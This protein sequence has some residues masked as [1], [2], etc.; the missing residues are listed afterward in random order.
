MSTMPD[1]VV[2]VVDATNLERNLFLTTQ[3]IDMDIRVVIALN[4]YDEFE[5]QGHRLDIRQLESILGIPIVPTVGKRGTG[6]HDVF[7]K[8]IETYEDRHPTSRSI[9]INYGEELERSI[10]VV[11]RKILEDPKQSLTN[12]VSGRF[13]ALKCLEGDEDIEKRLKECQNFEGIM[14]QVS[15][16]MKKLEASYNEPSVDQITQARYGFIAGALRETYV[17]K[18]RTRRRK[19]EII[20][21]FIT[22]RVWGIPV[23]FAFMFL[24]FFATFKLGQYPADWIDAGVAS[25]ATWVNA[26]MP[27]GMLKDLISQGIIGGV[28][29][30]IVFMP[31]ILILYFFTSLMEDTGYMA[32]AAFI[33][34]KAMHRIG[35]HGKSF[36]PMLMGFGCNV[37]AI[38]STR[39]IENKRDRLVT[40]LINPFMSCSARLPVFVL[41]ISAF[42]ESYRSGLLFLLYIIGIVLAALSAVLFKRTL[43]KGVDIPFVMEL[44]PYRVPSYRTILKHMWFRSEQYLRKIGVIILT[45]SIII[46]ALGYFPLHSEA[47]DAIAH[48]VEQLEKQ[49]LEVATISPTM[50][51]EIDQKIAEQ[52]M[53]L[54]FEKQKNSYIGRLGNAI[55]PV[56]APLGFDWR[57]SVAVL[58]GI[59]AKEIVVGTMGVLYQTPADGSETKLIGKLQDVKHEA[60]PDAGQAVFSPLVALAMMLFVLIYFPCIGVVSAIRRESGSWGWALF[61]V[62]YTTGVAWVIAMLVYQVG[63]LIGY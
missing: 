23:F 7:E 48:N 41:L 47:T 54:D 49:K 8:I 44:P 53:Q 42:F 31:N 4:M 6:L 21:D 26:V 52:Q 34:D 40:M 22:H 11:R 12:R 38:L 5:L 33:M 10:A 28:G 58:T 9:L 50:V 35:L 39:I 24:T 18:A 1:V 15:T 29:G 37:P 55:Q 51:N 43:V 62:G 32:R 16:E 46:W 59:A 61:S 2:N 17:H 14:L 20:D 19:T 25:L 60:G 57:M 63:T 56:M 27:N 45:A 36:I 13:L 3:L 30:V